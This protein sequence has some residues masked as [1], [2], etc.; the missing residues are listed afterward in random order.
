L[1]NGTGDA[2]DIWRI[3]VVGG[4]TGDYIN[5]VSSRI[6]FF[7]Q[8]TKCVLSGTGKQLPKWAYEQMEVSCS[9]NQR[10]IRKSTFWNIE[11]NRFPRCMNFC[12][13]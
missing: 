9:P 7:H 13:H 2:N 4:K 11:E 10:D 3:D 6:R 8:L 12:P 5:V 1:K